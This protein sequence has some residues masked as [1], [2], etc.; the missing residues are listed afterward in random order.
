MP[1]MKKVLVGGLVLASFVAGA[2]V[3]NADYTRTVRPHSSFHLKRGYVIDTVR[4]HA[5]G[6]NVALSIR[7]LG[8]GCDWRLFGRGPIRASIS[9]LDRRFL[10]HSSRALRV[11]VERW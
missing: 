7:C 2:P 1:K 4:I 9:E 8:D 3:A 5:N 6:R 11:R 10:S